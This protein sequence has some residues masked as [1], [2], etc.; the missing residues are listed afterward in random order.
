MRLADLCIYKVLGSHLGTRPCVD[1]KLTA[2]NGP[3]QFWSPFILFTGWL[4]LS[5]GW[6]IRGHPQWWDIYTV[7]EV[8]PE[9]TL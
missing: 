8:Y 4:R 7:S 9:L 2:V 3:V 6:N 5:G 1:V